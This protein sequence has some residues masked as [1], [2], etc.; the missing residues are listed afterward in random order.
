MKVLETKA[1][2]SQT[3]S[4]VDFLD[5]YDVKD[6]ELKS[7]LSS[8]IGEFVVD[9]IL[10]SVA[11]T[12]SP[13]AGYGSFKGL[14][15]EYKAL[16]KADGRGS[17]PNLEFTG[18]MLDSLDWRVKKSGVEIGV[19]GSDAP[20]ADGHN[21]LSGKSSLPLR[22]FLPKGKDTFNRDILKEVDGIIKDA[23]S[24]KGKRSFNRGDLIGINSK[25]EFWEY[26]QG[27]YPGFSRSDIRRSLTNNPELF[28]TIL[29]LG[30]QKWL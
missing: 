10:D 14:S 1:T 11:S 17:K 26:L 30:Y 4:L 2:K 13:L 16:K 6:P 12:N 7:R 19:Y 8:E 24:E 3:T 9:R 5:G 20:K 25:T 29:D 22:R 21:N 23:I 15:G 18:D 28:S 27:F